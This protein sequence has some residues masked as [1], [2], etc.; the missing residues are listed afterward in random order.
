MNYAWHRRPDVRL[1]AICLGLVMACGLLLSACRQQEKPQKPKSVFPV[2]AAIAVER[3]VPVLLRAIGNVEAS[4]SVELKS[5]VN[6]QLSTVHFTEG[7]EVAKGDLLFSLDPQHYQAAV[8][9]AEAALARDL[10]Q[11]GFARDKAVRYADLLQRGVVSQQEYDQLQTNA[12]ALAKQ[13]MAD[14][15]ILQAAQVDL[16]Y[17]TIKAPMSGRT[18]NLA[19]HAGSVVKANEAPGLVTINQ[20][21]PL[22]VAFSLPE[23]YLQEIQT[24][25]ASAPLTVSVRTTGNDSQNE[26]G[27]VSFLDNTVDTGT[28]TI[29]VKALFDNKSKKLWPGQF[30]NVTLS[31]KTLANA[32]VVPTEAVQIGQEGPYVFVIKADSTVESRPVAIGPAHENETVIVEGLQSGEQVVTEGQ[33]RL[34]T[35]VQVAIAGEPQESKGSRP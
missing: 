30:V 1:M 28:G 17:C 9:Q 14:R 2:S 25:I 8:M 11:E 29:K 4:S 5:Q 3:D 10:A 16:A 24:R 12:S 26:T 18:G 22:H 27:T 31:L 7:Q 6:G 33:M 13:V 35:G 23:R 15:A 21:S 20:I 19:V 34:R 32:V